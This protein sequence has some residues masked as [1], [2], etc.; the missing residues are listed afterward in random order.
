MFFLIQKT[1]KVGNEE[2]KEGEGGSVLTCCGAH[3]N[4][5][6]AKNCVLAAENPTPVET[7]FIFCPPIYYESRVRVDNR[8]FFPRLVFARTQNK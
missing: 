4:C 3:V 2:K 1:V 6:W 5:W 7:D 8:I